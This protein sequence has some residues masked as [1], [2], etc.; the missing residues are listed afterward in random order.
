[1]T[2][3]IITALSTSDLNNFRLFM[4][5][6]IHCSLYQKDSF[7]QEGGGGSCSRLQQFSG[8]TSQFSSTNEVFAKRSTQCADQN[9]VTFFDNFEIILGG[10]PNLHYFTKV[11]NLKTV[12]KKKILSLK[13]GC[14]CCQEQFAPL[15]VFNFVS[16]ARMD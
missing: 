1:M 5:P 3:G 2:H 16:L 10:V 15:H 9:F 12:K 13:F 14:N 7:F 4:L 6:R 11:K 8:R